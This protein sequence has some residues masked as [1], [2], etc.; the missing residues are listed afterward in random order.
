MESIIEQLEYLEKE[1]KGV[2][3]ETINNNPTH[4]LGMFQNIKQKINQIKKGVKVYG[5][6]I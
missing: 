6:N 2:D 4:I 1:I 5:T 3:Q